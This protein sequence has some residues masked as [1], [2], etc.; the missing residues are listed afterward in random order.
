MHP[1]IKIK[2]TPFLT[3]HG[4]GFAMVKVSILE[5]FFVIYLPVFSEL[6]HGPWYYCP[7]ASE[8]Y[9]KDMGNSTKINPQQ[10][11]QTSPVFESSLRPSEGYTYIS[12][13]G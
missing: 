4:H 1:I 6:G 8:I 13:L 11:Q 3:G 2:Y 9:P 5:C 7:T 12:K 10:P